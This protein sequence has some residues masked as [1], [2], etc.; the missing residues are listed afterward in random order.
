MCI[1]PI[2]PYSLLSILSSKIKRFKVIT[3]FRLY[4]QI[5]NASEVYKISRRY[6]EE[7]VCNIL[8][9]YDNYGTKCITD[10]LNLKVFVK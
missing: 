4:C 5:T 6:F 10:V 7:N 2:T 8:G 9:T 1:L 3:M